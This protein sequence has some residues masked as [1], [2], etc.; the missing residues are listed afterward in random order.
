M[1]KWEYD[2]SYY[3]IVEEASEKQGMFSGPL[4]K[5]LV[6]P[7]LIWTFKFDNGK[8]AFDLIQEKGKKGWELVSVTPINKPLNRDSCTTELFFSF[9]RMID[10]KE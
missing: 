4:D 2:F 3:G 1:P 9:K 7:S 8:T 5:Y 10:E 6:T